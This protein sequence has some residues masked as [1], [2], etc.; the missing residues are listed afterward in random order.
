L[1][2]LLP[3][4][5][6]PPVSLADASSRPQPVLLRALA[7]QATEYTPI[8]FMRQAGRA[9]PRYRTLRERFSFSE[10]GK[11][12]ELTADV[13]LLP[14]D[15][16]GV[17]GCIIFAD[18]MTPLMGVGVGVELVEGVGPVMERPFCTAH[19]LQALRDLEPENDVAP[20]L[21]A[22]RQ[23]RSELAGRQV[24]LLGFAGAP[25]TMASY[26]VEG[27][28]S[29][30]FAA[31]KALAL[32][33]PELWHQLMERI[34]A[35]TVAYLRAQIEAGVQ[36]VQVFDSWAGALAPAQYE[37]LALPYTRQVIESVCGSVPVINFSTGTSAYIEL[38]ARAGGDV[39]GF[40]WRRTI[41]DAWSRVGDIAVQGNLDPVLLLA[42]DA[43]EAGAD[44]ILRAVGR[45]PGHIFNLGHGVHPRTSVD[46][47]RRLV[48]F[49]HEASARIRGG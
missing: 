27:R 4:L 11:N 28:P 35:I 5:P 39:I 17:D 3:G 46:T 18:I 25:F 41:D 47:L 32:T 44:A 22:I 42:P 6:D 20:L 8:W 30:D 16:L 45:R 29:R 2:T 38:V 49:V 19:D 12:A 9:L 48:D 34:V 1:K 43:A 21:A 13:S 31:T 33:C 15:D 26:L 37:A 24:P 7:C 36:A 23:L 14:I 10:I 40:D